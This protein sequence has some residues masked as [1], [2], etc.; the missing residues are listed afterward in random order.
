MLKED[1]LDVEI[2]ENEKDK[3]SLVKDDFRDVGYNVEKY[4]FSLKQFK[5][6]YDMLKQINASLQKVLDEEK[7]KYEKLCK[8]NNNK[9]HLNLKININENF[10]NYK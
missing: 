10:G 1:K 5:M 2:M 3:L 8:K 7:I 4:K 9:K 6:K